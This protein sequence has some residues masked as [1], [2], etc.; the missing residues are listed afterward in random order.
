MT[1]IPA[2]STGRREAKPSAVLVKRILECGG[3]TAGAVLI[4]FGLAA[5]I[6]GFDGHTT[7]SDNLGQEKITARRT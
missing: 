3:F 5:I 1:T 2:K 6:M 4:A 7:V